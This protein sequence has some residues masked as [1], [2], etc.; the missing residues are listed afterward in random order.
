MENSQD[1]DFFMSS[2]SLSN[3]LQTHGDLY[4]DNLYDES[5]ESGEKSDSLDESSEAKKDL[6]ALASATTT[7][8]SQFLNKP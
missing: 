5:L 3:L 7:K 6:S 1:D 2:F 4:R 8:N